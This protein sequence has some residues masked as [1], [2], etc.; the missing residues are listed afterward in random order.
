MSIFIEMVICVAVESRLL[1]VD[2]GKLN[3]LP[4]SKGQKSETAMVHKGKT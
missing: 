4:I 3:F 2:T 1:I